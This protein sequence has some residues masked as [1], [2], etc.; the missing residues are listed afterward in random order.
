MLEMLL[1]R[2]GSG[3]ETRGAGSVLTHPIGWEGA[4]ICLQVS[5]KETTARELLNH[6]ILEMKN[7]ERPSEVKYLPKTMQLL[8]DEAQI[9]IPLFFH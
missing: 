3:A 4:G 2:D 7:Q 9:Q 8:I 6:L 1:G 5:L